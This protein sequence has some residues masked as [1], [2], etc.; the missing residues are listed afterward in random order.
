MSS[1]LL[2][3]NVD[4]FARA[5]ELNLIHNMMY[6]VSVIGEDIA[7]QCIASHPVKILVDLTAP[8]EGVINIGGTISKCTV[9]A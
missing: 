2:M 7:G 6:Y 4:T 9:Y 3:S 8:E 1:I 5:T